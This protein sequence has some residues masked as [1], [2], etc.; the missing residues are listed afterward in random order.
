MY[1][2]ICALKSLFFYYC[3]YTGKPNYSCGSDFIS[4]FSICSDF[5]FEFW[6]IQANHIFASATKTRPNLFA[7]RRLRCSFSFSLIFSS[8]KIKSSNQGPDRFFGW[9]CLFKPHFVV[10]TFFTAVCQNKWRAKRFKHLQHILIREF[11]PSFRVKY[12]N[13]YVFIL[14]SMLGLLY[15]TW[16]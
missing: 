15:R 16:S 5:G 2:N 8:H 6:Y 4:E 14:V 10:H 1:T 13:F 3:W 7:K 11:L 12:G 9:Y